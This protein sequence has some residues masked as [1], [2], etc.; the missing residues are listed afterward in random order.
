M[1][2]V[3]LENSGE[4]YTSQVYLVLGSFS[5]IEDVNTLVDVG[6]DPAILKSIERAPTGIGKWAVEQVVMTHDHSD[7]SALLPSVREK[8]HPKV[9][10]FSPHMDGVDCLLADGDTVKMGDADFEVI[11]MPGHSSDSVCFYN[12]T[13]GVLFVGDSPVLTASATGTYEAGFLAAMEKL[14]ALDV[15]QIYFGHGAPVTERCNERLR[16]SYCIV[17][18]TRSALGKVI[19]NQE[20]GAGDGVV[21]LSK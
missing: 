7:H 10:A 4:V 6:Q 11:H 20:S 19:T 15:R 16:E 5:R 3:T 8:F 1:R 21:A 13:E 17:A 2:I 18:G 14:C 12:R 9:F